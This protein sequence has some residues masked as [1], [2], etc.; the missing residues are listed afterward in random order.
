[1]ITSAI[2]VT[3]FQECSTGAERKKFAKNLIWSVSLDCG[4]A[5]LCILVL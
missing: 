3:L 4:I 2:L 1:M 5:F